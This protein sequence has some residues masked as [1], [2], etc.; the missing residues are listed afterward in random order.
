[1]L[2]PK[3]LPSLLKAMHSTMPILANSSSALPAAPA[4]LC[5][6]PSLPQHP[7]YMHHASAMGTLGLKVM[8]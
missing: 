7:H 5:P 3:I 6:A 4:Q 1:M 2:T 8:F